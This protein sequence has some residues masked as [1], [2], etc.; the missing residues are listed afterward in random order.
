MNTTTRA[1][2]RRPLPRTAAEHSIRN[3][4]ALGLGIGLLGALS[5]CNEVSTL[6]RERVAQSET[7][8]QQTQQTIGTS[9][10][11]AIELQQA[12]EQVGA[13]KSAMGKGQEQQ[14]ERS[15]AQARLYADLAVA[16]SQ[17]ANARKGADEVRASLDTLRG[18]TER[19]SPTPR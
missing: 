15:A 11:G 9:E 13:A 2:S 14:A 16:K 18:E 10:H 5:A 12:R 4:V 6:T 3:I 7:W 1:Q 19:A 8:V 17:S